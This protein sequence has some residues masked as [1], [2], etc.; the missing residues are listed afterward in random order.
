MWPKNFHDRLRQWADLR[1]RASSLDLNDALITVN[2]WWLRSPWTAYYL[3]WDDK[4]R[5]PDAWQLLADD[6]YC[7]LARALGIV[8]TLHML[9]RPDLQ[10]ISMADTDLGNL[11]LID[12]GKYIVNWE[13]G[14]LLNIASRKIV[15]KKRLD[16]LEL[17]HLTG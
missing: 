5:W 2:D 17:P 15:I 9:E 13:P 16:R 11:V 12:Q 7:D 6:I 3:H 14:T 8:Y 1:R 10:D 4:N